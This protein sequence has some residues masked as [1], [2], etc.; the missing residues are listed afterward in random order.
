MYGRD[1]KCIQIFSGDVEEGDHLGY[2]GIDGRI[3]LKWILKIR[4]EDVDCIHISKYTSS[5]EIV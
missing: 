3:I 2:L 1:E 5:C 4:C